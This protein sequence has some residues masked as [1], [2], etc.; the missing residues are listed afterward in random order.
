M[1]TIPTTELARMALIG[2]G[3]KMGRR[4][5][6]HLARHPHY[7]LRCVERSQASQIQLAERGL[8]V[9]T[10]EQAV[11]GAD[12]IIL[13]VPDK[14]LGKAAHAVVPLASPGTLVIMLDPAAAHA[15]ELPE[16]R[17]IS[18]F[19]SHPCHPSVFEHFESEVE[20]NDF[21]GGT[22]ARQ[23]IV[24]ALMQGPESDYTRSNRWRCSSQR[25]R[26]QSGSV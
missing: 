3:G 14:V 13:A 1:T 2:A 22:A 6:D 8:A 18:Y 15:G 5:I 20:R 21:F 9:M 23:A 17:D 16:R 19:V 7:E 4:I 11:A 25:W 10:V 26:R 12:A 24:C